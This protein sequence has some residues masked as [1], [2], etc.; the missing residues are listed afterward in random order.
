MSMHMQLSSFQ[1]SPGG[2]QGRKSPFNVLVKTFLT[3]MQC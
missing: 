2:K 1:T 3:D